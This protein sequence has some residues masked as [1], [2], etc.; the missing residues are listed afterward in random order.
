MICPRSET[1]LKP[2]PDFTWAV[3]MGEFIITSKTIIIIIIILTMQSWCNWTWAE[4]LAEKQIEEKV[5]EKPKFILI[6]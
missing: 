2:Q 1:E 4:C 6:F 3:Y 5:F